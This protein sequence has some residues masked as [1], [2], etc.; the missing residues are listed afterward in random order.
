MY[1]RDNP[2]PRYVELQDIYRRMHTQG[3]EVETE[4]GVERIAGDDAFPGDQLPAYL[5]PIGQLIERTGS[6]TVLDY[7]CGKGRQYGPVEIKDGQGRVVATSVAELW[8]VDEIALY[9]PGVAEHAALPDGPFDG[10]VSTDVLEHI[11][12]DDVF[13][14]VDEVFA[15]AARFVFANVACYPAKGRLLDGSNAHVTVEH[16]KWWLAVFEMAAARRPGVGF[17]LVCMGNEVKADGSVQL[18]Q[19][20]FSS[21]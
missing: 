13:W 12:R 2:S 17:S 14:V 21:L 8:G 19:V 11:P 3:Y 16:P 7:G 9:D 1:S 4:T 6:R 10:V 5:E 20:T 18:G 15:R